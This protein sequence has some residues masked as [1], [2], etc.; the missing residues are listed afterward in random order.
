MTQKSKKYKNVQLN[1]LVLI[2]HPSHHP[3]QELELYQSPQKSHMCP[4]LVLTLPHLTPKVT[5]GNVAGVTEELSFSIY[6]ILINSNVN[7]YTWRVAKVWDSA[8][9]EYQHHLSNYCLSNVICF[10][11]GGHY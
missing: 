1:K 10:S 5:T 3:N 9:T 4:I 11:S 7:S 6:L 2:Y 8:G